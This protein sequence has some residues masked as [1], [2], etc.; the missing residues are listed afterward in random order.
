M[1]EQ[2]RDPNCDL[3][4][5]SR[6]REHFP[7]LLGKMQAAIKVIPMPADTNMNGDVFGGWLM[8]K[9]DLAGSVSAQ[10]IAGGRVVARMRFHVQT[11]PQRGDPIRVQRMAGPPGFLRIIAHRSAFLPTIKGLDRGIDIEDPRRR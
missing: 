10:A 4:M 2:D 1:S 5:E 7:D 6:A 9:M 11:Q 8:T 3:R